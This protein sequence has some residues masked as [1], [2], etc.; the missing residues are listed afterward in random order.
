MSPIGFPGGGSSKKDASADAQR[1]T[2]DL[3]EHVWR[4]E[5]QVDQQRLILQALVSLLD[6]A[7]G[8]TE[9]A[10]LDQVR[11]LERTRQEA[12]PD[13]CAKCGRVFGAKQPRCIYCGEPRPVKSAFDLL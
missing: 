3:R 9:Q 8:V 6:R 4:L 11:S 2:S 10:L 12:P 5:R 7:Q 13:T 1:D